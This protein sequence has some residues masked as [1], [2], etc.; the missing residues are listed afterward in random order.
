MSRKKALNLA[1][2]REMLEQFNELCQVYGHGKQKGMVLS[3]AIL[4]F[5]RAHPETQGEFLE[6]VIKADVSSNVE[7]MLE[8]IRR[9][10]ALLVHTREATRKATAP[11]APEAPKAAP[12]AA[13]PEEGSSPER[14]DGRKPEPSDGSYSQHA[15]QRKAAK[16]TG[17]G[18]P[19]ARPRRK[20]EDFE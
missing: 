12:A 4:M 15:S 10:Q 5:L 18:G 14:P 2:P 3:A 13:A 17:K 1:I 16:K 9:E 20:Y 8:R 7:Q 11:E 19:I 6:Q